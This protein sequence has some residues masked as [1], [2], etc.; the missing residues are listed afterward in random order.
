[1]TEVQL[2]PEIVAANRAAWVAAL[3]S[4]TYAQSRGRLRTR[5]DGYC[6]LG[7]AETVRGAEW[8]YR[9]GSKLYAEPDDAGFYLPVVLADGGFEETF[10]S[11]EGARWL[12]LST[13]DPVV[14][15]RDSRPG[16]VRVESPYRAA[17]LA[18]L[19][20]TIKLSFAEIADVIADQQPSW[21]GDAGQVGAD[22][23]ARNDAHL[24]SLEETP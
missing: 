5:D 15:F 1:M 16:Y 4:G 21:T 9:L 13:P 3:R 18:E 2:S 19:N 20:D 22:V 6:C 14:A 17:S 11:R 7:V 10:L 24:A 12:G 8:R 23:E